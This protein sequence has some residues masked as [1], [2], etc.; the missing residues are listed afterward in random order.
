MRRAN[1][2]AIF[3]V[4][5]IHATRVAQSLPWTEKRQKSRV[6]MIPVVYLPDWYSGGA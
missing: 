5:F 4:I 1:K 6:E 3:R 2:L